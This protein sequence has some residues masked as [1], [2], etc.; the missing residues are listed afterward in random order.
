MEMTLL[1]AQEGKE[2]IIQR[3]DIKG[4]EHGQDADQKN[5]DDRNLRAH[6]PIFLHF[7]APFSR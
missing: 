2:Y 6:L 4:I 1:N 3:I 5:E 7:F